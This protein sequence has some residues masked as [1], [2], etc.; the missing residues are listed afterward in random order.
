MTHLYFLGN[1]SCK[2]M[3]CENV[4]CDLVK[5]LSDY[6][7]KIGILSLHPKH[8]MNILTNFVYSKLRWNLTIYHLSGTL[9][10]Q[11]LDNKANRYIRKWL[12]IPISGDF[13]HLRL[14]FKQLGIGLKLPNYCAK[15]L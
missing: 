1:N 5:R 9:I 11:N 13:N 12:G 4:K 7:E 10:V 6:L 15:H 8:K 14:N 2:N 3:S